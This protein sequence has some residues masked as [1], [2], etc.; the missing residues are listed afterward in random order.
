M[1]VLSIYRVGRYMYMY[2]YN[3]T[4]VLSDK[5]PSQGVNY[6]AVIDVVISCAQ[7]VPVN[8][9]YRLEI[10]VRFVLEASIWIIVT[11]WEILNRF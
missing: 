11:N 8:V 7:N 1:K 5:C 3:P 2:G 4:Y 6:T 9:Q 10:C